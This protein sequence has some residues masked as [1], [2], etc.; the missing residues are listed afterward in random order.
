[1]ENFYEQ[2]S[3]YCCSR[4]L[5]GGDCSLG[6]ERT[7]ESWM[8]LAVARLVAFRLRAARLVSSRLP[9]GD[10]AAAPRWPSHNSYRRV[11]LMPRTSNLVDWLLGIWPHDSLSELWLGMTAFATLFLIVTTWWDAADCRER[12]GWQLLVDQL[13]RKILFVGVNLR[14]RALSSM[15]SASHAVRLRTVTNKLVGA[16]AVAVVTAI[17]VWVPWQS[18][19]QGSIWSHHWWHSD[20]G[21][22]GRFHHGCGRHMSIG[23]STAQVLGLSAFG[24]MAF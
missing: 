21:H 22:H 14:R 5:D 10:A 16:A 12:L 23:C 17:V 24:H 11:M 2:A 3:R 13:H 18:M 4:G 9:H 7:N 6:P 1:M 15:S 20:F 8:G 19:N